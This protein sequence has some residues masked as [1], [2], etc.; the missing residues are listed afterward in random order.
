MPRQSRNKRQNRLRQNRRRQS[1]RQMRGGNLTESQ[2]SEL[3]MAIEDLKAKIEAMKEDV[4]EEGAPV[5]ARKTKDGLPHHKEESE[6][7]ASEEDKSEED[8]S[9]EGASVI[10]TMI[11]DAKSVFD[12]DEEEEEEEVKGGRRKSRKNRKQKKIKS[13]RRQRRR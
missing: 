9:V 1:R 2:S 8:K 11:D 6:D 7:D 3:L 5:G 12:G 4:S 10:D 13:Q